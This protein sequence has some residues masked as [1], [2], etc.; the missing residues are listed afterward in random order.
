LSASLATTPDGSVRKHGKIDNSR[1]T[2]Y[3]RSY[4]VGASAGLVDDDI[5]GNELGTAYSYQETGYKAVTTCIYNST[6][7]FQFRDLHLTMLYAATGP[8]PNSVDEEYS[9]YVGHYTSALFAMR[10]SHI[11]TPGRIL[12]ITAGES[13][14]ALNKTQCTLDFVPTLFNV[15]V[16]LRNRE[17]N[18]TAVSRVAEFDPSG[19]VTWVTMRQFELISNDQTNIYTSL[20]GDSFLASIHDYNTSR[21]NDPSHPPTEQEATIAGLTN[22]INSMVD[23][24]LVGYASA[25]LMIGNDSVVTTASIQL[26]AL[27]LGQGMYIY[28][29]AVANTFVVL[30]VVVEA[31]RTKGWRNLLAFDYMDPGYL[32]IGSSKGGKGIAKAANAACESWKASRLSWWQ[33]STNAAI[34]R[35][36]VVMNGG[37]AVVLGN[38]REGYGDEKDSPVLISKAPPYPRSWI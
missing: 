17:I 38:R 35:L 26:N 36:S 13:Y 30:L 9:V 25:Q 15:S 5:L 33:D 37:Q 12:A 18:V 14:A 29:I 22:S 28:A 31:I 16:G 10:V 19:N 23:D 24:M 20:V 6:S 21:A 27:R 8:L 4:G 3:G 1:F 34:G 11:Q 7:M 32:I 2:Y